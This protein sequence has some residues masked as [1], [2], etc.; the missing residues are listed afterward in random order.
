M[1]RYRNERI[2]YEYELRWYRAQASLDGA[3]FY[4]KQGD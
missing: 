3:F 2:L 1:Q 4:A